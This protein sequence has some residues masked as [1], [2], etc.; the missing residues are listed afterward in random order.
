MQTP[1]PM[2]DQKA[3]DVQMDPPCEQEVLPPSESPC[4]PETSVQ[5]DPSCEPPESE[6]PEAGADAA[7]VQPDVTCVLPSEPSKAK[8]GSM[9]LVCL[10]AVAVLLA[11]AAVVL[12][13]TMPTAPA[14]AE[15][16][17]LLESSGTTYDLQGHTLRVRSADGEETVYPA[18]APVQA[19]PSISLVY[20]ASLM[21]ELHGEIVIPPV[22]TVYNQAYRVVAGPSEVLEIPAADGEYLVCVELTWGR[23]EEQI[24][25]QCYFTITVSA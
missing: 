21:L 11:A 19:D 2:P 16:I 20:D 4:E 17:A 5:E 12:L 3:A 18:L 8:R 13:C 15:G 7:A 23:G 22:I 1:D 25:K 24:E 6:R 9:L 10:L 14:V